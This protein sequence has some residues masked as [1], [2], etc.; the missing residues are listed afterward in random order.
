[1]NIKVNPNN[2]KVRDEMM[3]AIISA[4]GGVVRVFEDKKKALKSDPAKRKIK[5]KKPIDIS[6]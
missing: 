2:I 4:T 5:H 1:M 3:K 6:E